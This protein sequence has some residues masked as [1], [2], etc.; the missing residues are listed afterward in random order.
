MMDTLPEDT[1]LEIFAHYLPK[2]S[3][4]RVNDVDKWHNLVHVCRRWRNI[5]FESPRRLNLRI[6]CTARTR[7]RAM[8]NVW[9]DLPLVITDPYWSA[10][11]GR[12]L[13]E[14]ADNIV[15]ALELK[16]R[17]RQISFFNCPRF[18][19]TRIMPAMLG[20]FP[21]LTS[22]AITL[23]D[24]TIVV[25]AFPEAFLVESAPRL[26]SCFLMGIRFPGIQKLLLSTNRLV[27]LTLRDTPYSAYI[28]PEAMVTCLSAMV[29]L[30]TFWLEFPSRGS[31]T[32]R[33]RHWQRRPPLTPAVLPSLTKFRYEGSCEYME[34]LL[35]RI[36]APSLSQVSLWLFYLPI[37]DTPQLHSF[38]AR[39]RIFESCSK[40][41]VTF[42]ANE[43]YFTHGNRFSLG[44][45]SL[46]LSSQLSSL[47][48]ISTLSF[49]PV[50]T[51]KR[52]DVRL[53]RNAVPH[54]QYVLNA[55]V[56]QWLQF[57]RPFMALKY[58]CLDSNFARRIVPALRYS[59]LVT[60][61]AMQALPALQS[62]FLEGISYRLQNAVEEFVSARQLSGLPVAIYSWDGNGNG[63]RG[64]YPQHAFSSPPL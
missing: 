64:T 59:Q 37:F 26:R 62:I 1:L 51:S 13:I 5:V 8:L 3:E 32:D 58:L 30:K 34:D 55:E 18:I 43:V 29:D 61:G 52:L 9:P 22:L 33:L 47:V 19:W 15:A 7:V 31:I 27:D 17:I 45:S 57:F 21:A 41:V 44:I 42:Y 50:C 54:H 11:P 60:E 2:D 40:S 36:D 39:T 49:P 4:S 46:T 38:L 35:S 25:G 6:R 63:S 20:S 53:G 28:S 48:Q 12:S 16:D 56:I 14:G 10:R 23:E 24:E